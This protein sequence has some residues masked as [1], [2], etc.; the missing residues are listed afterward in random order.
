MKSIH[1]KSV[2][3]N[4]AEVVHGYKFYKETVSIMLAVL[5][6]LIS[7]IFISSKVFAENTNDPVEAV[8]EF[9]CLEPKNIQSVT[10][11]IRIKSQDSNAPMP[12]QDSVKINQS[13]KGSFKI[14][15]TE[16]GTYVYRVYQEKGIDPNVKYDDTEYDVYVYV[17]NGDSNKLT[18]MV[19]VN[20]ADT[21]TKPSSMD[22]G[23]ESSKGSAPPEDETS[24]TP[25]K[26]EKTEVDPS[27]KTEQS[28]TKTS[29]ESKSE[30]TT[31]KA[32]EASTS[33]G[34]T[35]TNPDAKVINA[36]KAKTADEMHLLVVILISIVSLLCILTIL[37]IKRNRTEDN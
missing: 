4:K 14:T 32:P 5:C 6:A 22:F 24:E 20:Y 35:T 33:S 9:D 23:N 37:I 19:S 29:T 11:N 12:A 25:G 3:L 13:G 36:K 8:I 26:K 17:T 28:S 31:E 18:Y 15:I 2:Q 10:Y 34:D 27:E 30:S 7:S 16:P 21:D 1:V